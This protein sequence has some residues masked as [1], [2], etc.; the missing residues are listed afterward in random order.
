MKRTCILPALLGAACFACAPAPSGIP[1]QQVAELVGRTA[2]LPQSC[3]RIERSEVLRVS[4][5]N[6]HLV[7]YGRT[8]TIWANDLGPNC[9]L[10]SGDTLIVQP[11]RSSYCR[12]DLVRSANPASGMG[13]RSCFLGDFIPYRR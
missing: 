13:G 3:V 11:I 2:G 8:G 10:S 5:N 7:L 12:G 9:R 4:P 1:A 6:E